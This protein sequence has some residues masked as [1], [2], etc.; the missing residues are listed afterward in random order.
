MSVLAGVEI[1]GGPLVKVRRAIMKLVRGG[2][3]SRQVD[4]G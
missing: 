3:G 1:P 2:I 4:F